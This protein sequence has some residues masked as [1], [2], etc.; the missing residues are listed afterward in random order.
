MKNSPLSRFSRNLAAALALCGFALG[1]PAF[2]DDYPDRPI[3]LTVGFGPGTGPDLLARV[4]AEGLRRELGE[5]VV[6]ENRTGAGGVI[7]MQHLQR[8]KPDGYSLGL[9]ALGQTVLGPLVQPNA[10][11]DIRTDFDAI[12]QVGAIDFVLVVPS[13]TA[14][15]E[16]FTEQLNRPDGIFMGTMGSGTLSHL[17]IPALIEVLGGSAEPVHFKSAADAT[18]AVS[19]GDVQGMLMSPSMAN[20]M[21]QAG[22][23]V[24]VAATGPERTPMMPEVPTF[25]EQDEDFELVAWFGLFAPKGTPEP[26][27]DRIADAAAEVLKEDEVRERLLAASIGVTPRPREQFRE[28]VMAEAERWEAAMAQTQRVGN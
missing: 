14:T 24:P 22:R 9:G 27:L 2:A 19:N 3:H 15:L 11:F 4:L 28:F 1:T 13:Q 5:A 8:Q 21:V 10:G 20:P 12:A 7:A 23:I 6:V 18:N 16:G 26:I 17:G 25:L